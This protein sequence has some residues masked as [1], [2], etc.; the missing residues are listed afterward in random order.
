MKKRWIRWRDR[1]LAALGLQIRLDDGPGWEALTAGGGPAD[2][3][4][5]EVQQDLADVLEAWR[6]NFL[7]R[8]IVRLTTAYVVGDGI[9]AS[10]GHSRV[11][12]FA[13]EFWTHPQNRLAGRLPT[14]CDE[15]TRSGEWFIALFPNPVNGMQYVRAVPARQ[16]EQVLTDPEDYEKETGYL[17]IVPGQIERKAWKSGL[18]ARPDEPC[19][20]HYTIN[21]PVGATR[22]EGD[23]TPIL[24]WAR[25]YTEWLKDRV[26]FNRLRNEL[27][28]VDIEIED[29]RDLDKWQKHY[30]ANPPTGGSISVHGKG[31][32]ITYPSANIQ[33]YDASPDGLAVRLAVA[34]GSNVPLHFLAEGSSATRSTA[35]EMGDPT[36]RHYRMRQQAV[37]AMLTDLVGQAYRRR[38]ALLGPAVPK[39]MGLM[40]EAP[41]VSRADNQALAQS[42][43]TVVEALAVMRQHGWVDD[44]TAI[45]LSFKFAGELL[46]E[47][48]IKEL[49]NGTDKPAEPTAPAG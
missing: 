10:A 46:P 18:T 19:L 5:A 26:R 44:E 36:H 17:E 3:P 42:A 43:K 22:G 21:Q 45:R 24:P 31:H 30:Q 29:D 32:T 4:W 9:K 16:I 48:K 41:D 14:W 8:Q 35:S 15:L 11:N 23:L 40:V 7:I 1:A 2:R 20:L 37:A 34:A 13:A 27:A 38:C 28:A 49:L 47:E 25:R 33:G 6:K 39:E 12:R